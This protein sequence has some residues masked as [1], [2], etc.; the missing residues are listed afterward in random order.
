MYPMSA[1][2]T[3]SSL[4]RTD[5][6]GNFYEE[7]DNSYVQKNLNEGVPNF[8]VSVP[9]YLDYLNG[10]NEKDQKNLNGSKIDLNKY[11]FG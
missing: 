2:Q 5:E 4:N 7:L 3:A 10:R 9:T 6:K 11:F 8:Y 1:R